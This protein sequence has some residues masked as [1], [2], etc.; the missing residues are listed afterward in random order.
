MATKFKFL[1]DFEIFARAYGI[2]AFTLRA[3]KEVDEIA[4]KALNTPGPVIV[5]CLVSAEENVTPMV[6]AGKSINEA[7]DC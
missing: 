6:P 4:K 1:P 3:E 5:N 2:A 7:I